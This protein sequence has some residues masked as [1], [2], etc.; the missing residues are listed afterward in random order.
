MQ[1][2]RPLLKPK[3]EFVWNQEQEDAFQA[4]KDI[5][6]STPVQAYFDPRKQTQLRVDASRLNGLGLAL[7]QTQEDGTCRLVQAASRFLTPKELRYDM[8]EIEALGAAWAVKKCHIFLHGLPHFDLIVDHKPLIPIFNQYRIDEIENPRLQRL[9]MKLTPYNFTAVWRSGK[10]HQAADALSRSP[11]DQPTQDDIVDQ[12]D[13]E[14]LVSLIL[15]VRAHVDTISNPLSTVKE[16]SSKDTQMVKSVIMEGCPDNKQQTPETV[17]E[18]WPVRSSLSIRDDIILYGCRT[19]IPKS[20][21]CSTLKSLHDGH[22]G[23]EK[24]KRR[25]RQSIYWP[26]IDRDISNF[27]NACQEC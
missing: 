5:L 6:T 11:I 10:S 20:L 24:A 21:R 8:I 3:N 9:R 1:P 25:A 22:Q 17:R 7:T 14:S 16:T 2:L 27:I 4:T 13:T 12:E 15:S 26:G 19:V 23:M 18:F